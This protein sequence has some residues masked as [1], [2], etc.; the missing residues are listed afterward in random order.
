MDRLEENKA[1]YRRF[2][3]LLNSQK[4]DDLPEVLDPGAYREI[5]V[6]AMQDWAAY[7]E[8]VASVRQVVAAV[9][10]T[11]VNIEDMVAEGDK[12]YARATVTGTNTGSLMGMPPTNKT[13][14][15]RM[16]D[17]VK[18]DGGRIVERIQMADN[19]GMMQQLMGGM[20][21]MGGSPDAGG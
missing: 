21:G 19:M 18:I 1:I 11:H 16:F 6:G 7:D 10:D 4:F 9:N 20:P 17:Y 12:V 3:D 13:F 15:A 8:A 2:I 14:Q 5:C